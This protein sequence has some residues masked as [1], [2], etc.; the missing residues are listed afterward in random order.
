MDQQTR[1]R[2][3]LAALSASAENKNRKLTKEDVAEF[4][5]DMDLNQEQYQ[6]VYAYL[7]SKKIQVE[8]VELPKM[9]VE[10]IPYTEEE[11]E[12]LSQYKKDMLYVKKQP[13]ETLLQLFEQAADGLLQAKKM[14]IEHYMERVLEIA[15]EYAHQGLL[16]QDLVQEGNLGLMIGVDTLGLKEA[17]MSCE[18]HLENEIHRAIRM[19]LDEQNGSKS[20]EEQVTEKLNKLADS[21][22]EL[23][24]D[25]GRQITPDELSIY[26]DM[27]LEEIEDL[28]R[29]AGE[30]I[31]MAE[32][33]EE[34]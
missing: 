1:F 31:E 5:Q 11:Q 15:G 32:T 26:L 17:E 2:T 7:A 28:L 18:V 4:L 19:A 8:G 10:E 12:F 14:L 25:M 27:P 16:I 20:T 9:P 22:T 34:N 24:E 30:N 23:T 13:R 33:T 3:A 29:I 6:L 21:I